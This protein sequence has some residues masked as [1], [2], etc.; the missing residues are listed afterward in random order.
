MKLQTMKT[1]GQIM[2]GRRMRRLRRIVGSEDYHLHSAYEAGEE[3]GR[4]CAESEI[5]GTHARTERD[6]ER[7]LRKM[8]RHAEKY[9]E[10]M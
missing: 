5:L 3:Y 1:I 9:R 6:K 8:R 7:C 4:L 2:A 10:G